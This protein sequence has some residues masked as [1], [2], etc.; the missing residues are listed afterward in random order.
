[1]Q[2]TLYMVDWF[3]LGTRQV[4]EMHDLARHDIVRWHAFVMCFSADILFISM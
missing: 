4:V 2:V 1:M 3:R